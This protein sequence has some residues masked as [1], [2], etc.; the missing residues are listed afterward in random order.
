MSG[1]YELRVLPVTAVRPADYNPRVALRPGDPDYEKLRAS[2]TDLGVIDP[3]VWNENTGNLVGGH[4][5]LQVCMD[6]GITEVPVFVVHLSEE[7]EK[8][9]NLALNKITGRFDETKLNEILTGLDP[10]VIKLAGFDPK[11]LT[12]ILDEYVNPEEDNFDIGKALE[13]SEQSPRTQ[14]G[15]IITLGD[16]RLM[17]GDSTNPSDM[18]KL[19]NGNRADMVFTDPPYGVAIGD[20]NKVLAEHACS[21]G[22]TK[23][24]I[25]DTLPTEELR[26]MLTAA[27]RN[28]RENAAADHC[29]YYV[30]APQGGDLGMMMMM[31]M[32]DAGLPVRHNL[33]WIKNAA[34]FS[35][36]RL[37]YEYRHEP[38][39]YTWTKSHIFYGGY[40]TTVVDDSKPL[41]KMNK[42]ELKDLVRA[43]SGEHEQSTIYCDKPT[44]SGLHP[45]MKPVKLVARFITNSSQRGGVRGGHLRRQRNN[46]DRLGTARTPVLHDGDGPTLLRRDRPALGR[47]HREASGL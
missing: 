17:C 46:A 9:A 41:D 8:Q 4:Q 40:N 27:M 5:R 14:R 2:I 19:M 18:R 24:I 6:M 22:I 20:K 10:A 33:I 11:E 36:G 7:K 16:H 30:S 29:S 37:D 28:L 31:M 45:T 15:D 13:N 44:K 1:G 43:L 35:M 23:N 26:A 12:T 32:R 42:S 34:T 38:I 25:G 21:G 47:V 39:F 3:L